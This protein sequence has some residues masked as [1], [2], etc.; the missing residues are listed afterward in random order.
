[1]QF[2]RKGAT[3]HTK[4]MNVNDG[5]IRSFIRW[6]SEFVDEVTHPIIIRS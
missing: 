2:L 5:D 6:G 3:A 4:N 1:M